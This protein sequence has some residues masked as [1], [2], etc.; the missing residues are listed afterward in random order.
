VAFASHA[1]QFALSLIVTMFIA[2]SAMRH[3]AA[4]RNA[5]THVSLQAAVIIRY[6]GM[7]WAWAALT[8]VAVYQS[9]LSWPPWIG[10]FVLMLAGALTLLFIAKIL[11]RDALE[12]TDDPRIFDL[13]RIVAK[14][15]FIATCVAVGG[16]LAFGKFSVS[17]FA[18][19]ESWAAMNILLTSAIG[20]AVMSGYYLVFVG[21]PE[22]EETS[23]DEPTIASALRRTPV[24]AGRT[25]APR[26]LRKPASAQTGRMR[27]A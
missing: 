25:K 16:L 2:V 4:F 6:M 10:A 17:A 7:V 24:L 26:P 22:P 14:I 13:V 1:G 5:G 11:D 21:M 20:L 23:I 18:S 9:L 12:T 27:T 19:D 3:F 8:L 15:Q